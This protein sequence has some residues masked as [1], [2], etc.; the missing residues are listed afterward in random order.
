MPATAVE[1]QALL[2]GEVHLRSAE[3]REWLEFPE[4]SDGSIWDVRFDLESARL[5]D[6]ATTVRL[7]Q[8][9]VKE[10]WIV[11]LNG[12]PL[13]DL[14]RNE[15]R[16]WT[17][18]EVPA[19][20]L[21]TKGNRLTIKPSRPHPDKSDDIRI[22]AVAWIPQ[23]KTQWLSQAS[24]KLEVRDDQQ[25]LIPGRL[26]IVDEAGTLVETGA[27]STR[28]T[29]VRTG[30]IYTLD[31]PV[32]IP[33]PAGNYKIYAGRGFEY[34]LDEKDLAVAAGES[35]QARL[36]IRRQVDTSG[37]VACDTHVHT[38]THSGHGD[39][40]VQERMV[41]LAGEGIELPIATDHNVNIDHRPFAAACGADRYF[42]PVIG[43]EVTT[44]WGHFNVFPFLP[45]TP[46]PD[47]RGED[48]DAI[49]SAIESSPQVKVVIL[50]HARD[51]H[52]NYRPLGPAA[53]NAAVGENLRGWRLRA[54]AM[55]VLNSS[56]TQT[57]VMQLFRDWMTL[58]NRGL[59][60]TPVGCSDSHDVARHFVGQ[61]RT[62]VR[63]DDHDPSQ[64]NVGMATDNFVAGR[65]R[66]SYGLWVELLANGRWTSGELAAV[67]GREAPGAQPSPAVTIRVRGPHWVRADEVKLFVNGAAMRTQRLKSSDRQASDEGLIWEGVWELPP[68]RHDVVVTAIASG[69]GIEQPYWPTAKPYQPTGPQWTPRLIA[70]SGAVRLDVDGDGRF[71]SA[72]DYALRAIAEMGGELNGRL[73]EKL[74]EYDS[75]TTAQALW[76]LDQLG[77]SP[78][79]DPVSKLFLAGEPPVREGYAGYVAAWRASRQAM[80]R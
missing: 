14:T 61:G 55:E 36:N 51:I 70:C 79:R 24:L 69:P 44:K 49:F 50:N 30:V 20:L 10:R 63:C 12:N 74:G 40:S 33:A 11:Q 48:W 56:A 75:A 17:H 29:A 41:T 6:G 71:Q 7:R 16:M 45:G 57:D 78:L 15:N 22:A 66:V 38:L 47:H 31:A 4:R 67:S 68:L 52:S 58:L 9:D 34:S 59:P 60:I 64:L 62:Y 5:P 65:V 28:T 80:G 32:S 26:T 37:W 54:N 2:K 25:R 3:Q 21:K 13:G 18:L 27:E 8:D 46:P 72:R 35:L 42:T 23:P 76:L 1:P 19:G 77:D 73:V 53:F 39:S 43:N